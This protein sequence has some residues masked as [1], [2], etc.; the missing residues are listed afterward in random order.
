MQDRRADGGINVLYPG[1]SSVTEISKSMPI[2]LVELAPVVNEQRLNRLDVLHLP[3]PR[4][5]RI[6]AF[7]PVREI[8]G[9][10]R[11]NDCRGRRD[12]DLLILHACLPSNAARIR[13]RRTITHANSLRRALETAIERRR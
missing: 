6:G 5:G 3:N 12:D 9:H 2:T 1:T 13:A 11:Q 8:P 4:I 10:E 7:G